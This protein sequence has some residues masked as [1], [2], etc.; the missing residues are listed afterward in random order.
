[1]PAT[2]PASPLPAR[3]RAILAAEARFAARAEAFVGHIM[4]RAEGGDPVAI[5][6]CM[7][8]AVP[9]GRAGAPAPAEDR[10]A[11]RRAIAEITA[12]LVAGRINVRQTMWML[13]ALGD[14]VRRLPGVAALRPLAKAEADLAQA[15]GAMGMDHF[16]TVPLQTA[17]DSCM[18]HDLIRKPVPTFRDHAPDQSN[19]EETP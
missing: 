14:D 7:E 4:A 1:M 10:D 19:K 15:M 16:I 18:E 9:L 6:L 8:R 11:A 17:A 3:N 5:R 13:D 2:D 12:A